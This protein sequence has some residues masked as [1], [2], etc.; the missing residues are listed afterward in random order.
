MVH[1]INKVFHHIERTT[2]RR[3]NR[4]NVRYQCGKSYRTWKFVKTENGW[5]WPF[6]KL[7]A[8]DTI[9]F[10]SDRRNNRKVYIYKASDAVFKKLRGDF[11]DGNV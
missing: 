1:N 7:V 10:G 8:V 11:D 3:R 5:A 9:L 2:V 4:D 6:T